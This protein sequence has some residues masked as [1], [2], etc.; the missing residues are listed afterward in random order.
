[1]V[2]WCFLSRLCGSLYLYLSLS[3][4]LHLALSSPFFLLFPLS[5]FLSISLF[6]SMQTLIY[7]QRNVFHKIKYDLKGHMRPLLCPLLLEKFRSFWSNYNLMNNFCPCFL[8]NILLML[9][10]KS[11]KTILH[12][13]KQYKQNFSTNGLNFLS[14]SNF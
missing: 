11:R 8:L 12:V 1:M 9:N 5:I 6:C 14:S 10:S 3:L 7:T 2:R 13:S 4:T